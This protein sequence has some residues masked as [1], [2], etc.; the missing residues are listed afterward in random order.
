MATQTDFY[1]L[2]YGILGEPYTAVRKGATPVDFTDYGFLG[3]PLTVLGFPSVGAP[4]EFPYWRVL[5]NESNSGYCAISEIQMAQT[6]GGANQCTG[7]VV[8]G[9][10]TIINASYGPEIAYDGVLQTSDP[11]WVLV[12][13][14][15]GS[16]AYHFPTPK[17]IR[18]VKIKIA[19]QDA[20]HSPK[21]FDVQYSA[22]GT[23]WITA[24][25]VTG[26]T[27]WALAE[28]RTY[29]IP[30]IGAVLGRKP[31]PFQF[32]SRRGNSFKF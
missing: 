13:P 10:G 29:A 21:A 22:D 9:T 4:G 3:E 31:R 8:S 16:A 24:L 5:V 23:N 11:Y 30:A 17:A 26:Q 32:G 6:S 12:M 27:G 15:V 14:P 25:S 18:E 7:G 2:D 20:T 19:N 28:T 1:K